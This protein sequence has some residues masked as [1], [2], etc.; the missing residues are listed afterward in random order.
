MFD[1][2]LNVHREVTARFQEKPELNVFSLDKDDLKTLGVEFPFERNADA[3][4][5]KHADRIYHTRP[6]ERDG[7][8]Q[9]V[10]LEFTRKK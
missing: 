2:W 9:L 10:A 3:F 5:A 4:F 7:G 6:S 1:P 8:N